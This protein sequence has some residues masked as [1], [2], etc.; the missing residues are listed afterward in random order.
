MAV[1]RFQ[2]FFSP[3]VPEGAQRKPLGGYE[4]IDK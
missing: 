2:A 4:T 1:F 3:A